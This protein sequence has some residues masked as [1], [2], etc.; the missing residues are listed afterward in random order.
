MLSWEEK[1]RSWLPRHFKAVDNDAI[2][3]AL[4]KVFD[5]LQGDLSDYIDQTFITEANSEY[6]NVHGLERG[7]RRINYGTAQSPNLESDTDFAN[8]VRR[9]K[10]NRSKAHIIDN[11]R[12]VLG[13]TG[14]RVVNDYDSNVLDN[15]DQR[16]NTVTV[17]GGTYGNQGPLDLKKRFN[18]FSVMIDTPERPP[19]A[20]FDSED[21][22]DSGNWYD[23][24]VRRFS[25]TIAS[26]IFNL[27][28]LKAPGGSG[29]RLLVKDFL[30]VTIGTEAQQE[31]ELNKDVG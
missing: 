23:T 25:Q 18:C 16:A 2:I 13:V 6:L 12:S 7:F 29:F 17:T 1:I 28:K 10:Y 21:F 20:F 31:Q 3:L 26:I 30:G 14:V 22:Y 11:V 5:T 24:P 27:I 9:I 15:T 19:L 8:R 4:A